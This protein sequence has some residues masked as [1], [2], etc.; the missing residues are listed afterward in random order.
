MHYH[1]S[2]L[3]ERSLEVT[4]SDVKRLVSTA[5]LHFTMA[6][7]AALQRAGRQAVQKMQVAPAPSMYAMRGFAT[8][9]KKNDDGGDGFDPLEGDVERVFHTAFDTWEGNDLPEIE[10]KFENPSWWET[11]F[12]EGFTDD[13]KHEVEMLQVFEDLVPYMDRSWESTIHPLLDGSKIAMQ[14]NVTLE[15]FDNKLFLD[16]QTTY[17][18]KVTMEVPLSSLSLTDA[19]KEIFIQLCGPR[20]NKNKKLFK[21]TEDRYEKRV[22][23]HKRLCEILRDLV[24]ASVEVSAQTPT[25]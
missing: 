21:F 12:P 15:D 24:T 16:D 8:Y 14:M 4:V 22:Y 7:R 25:A 11:D 9:Q 6:F 2:I 1:K 3:Y 10:E 17:D 23:N 13:M 18:T 20:Y 5:F 19:Q